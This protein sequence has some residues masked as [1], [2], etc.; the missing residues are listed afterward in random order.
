MLRRPRALAAVALAVTASPALASVQW[1]SQM[2][3]GSDTASRSAGGCTISPGWLPHSLRID[4]PSHHH[5]TL[6]YA[7][8]CHDGVNQTPRVGVYGYGSSIRSQV[9][10]GTKTI[11]VTLTVS[12]SR[13]QVN[14]VGVGYYSK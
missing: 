1:H 6:T 14:S 5:A 2:K 11:R 3:Y 7:F 10:V 12:G 4:C 9:S 13:S 8:T